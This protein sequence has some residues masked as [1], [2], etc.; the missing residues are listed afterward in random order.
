MLKRLKPNTIKLPVSFTNVQN[1]YVKNVQNVQNV[2]H[3]LKDFGL[4]QI[5]SRFSF[6]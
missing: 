3:S 6:F 4:I 5:D 1:Y 2:I